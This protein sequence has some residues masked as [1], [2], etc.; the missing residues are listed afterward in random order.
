[1]SNLSSLFL[2]PRDIKSLIQQI[3][4]IGCGWLGLP[5]AKHLIAKGYTIKGSTTSNAKIETLKNAAINGYVINLH[6]NGIKGNLSQFLDGSETIIINVPPGLRKNPNKNH[7]SEMRHLILATEKENIKNVLYISSTSIFKDESNFPQITHLSQ[8]NSDSN[9]SKQ[10]IE[11]EHILQNDMF[12]PPDSYK[13]NCF[14][15]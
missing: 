15:T 1:M 2:F 4:I 11:I 13:Y 12:G 8:P 10:L 9:S 7:I 14:Q 5:L 6:E 3:S